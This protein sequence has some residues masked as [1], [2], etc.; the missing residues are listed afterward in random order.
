MLSFANTIGLTEFTP[1]ILSSGGNLIIHLNP[2]PIVARLAIVTSEED[3]NLVNKRLVREI[4]IAR[5]LQVHGVPVIL[6]TQTI[7]A[8]PYDVDGTWMT[9]WDYVPPTQLQPIF[10]S[11]AVGLVKGLTRAMKNF[12]EDLPVLGVWQRTCQSAVR[13]TEH[14]DQRIQA[15][16]RT[17]LKV[18]E[19]MRMESSILVPCHGDAHA[20]NL[21]PSPKGWLWN[22]FEDVSMMPEY[23]DLASY[24]GNLVLFNGFQEPTFK[25]IMNHTDIIVDPKAFG[26]AMT[27]RLLMSTLGNLDYA[28]GG[29][30]DLG[31]ATRQ[32][33]LTGNCINHIDQ[34]I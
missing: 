8:G 23:W 27:A 11:E 3:A 12:T 1:V 34:Y 29:Y 19:Q 33:E 25:Y 30:G 24:V 32:L 14:S 26:Y 10:P 5:H 21:I 31:F 9:F 4:Q 17:F 28:F 16:L 2:H 7:N 6:P 18:D 13:L 15:L 20:R 22:D